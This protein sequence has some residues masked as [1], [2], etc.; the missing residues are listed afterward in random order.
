MLPASYIRRCLGT[1]SVNALEIYSP[2]AVF[3]VKHFGIFSLYLIMSRVY[4]FPKGPAIEPRQSNTLRS[5]DREVQKSVEHVTHALLTAASP[6]D[7]VYI[8]K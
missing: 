2:S 5:R 3:I 6:S 1:T 8:R 7:Y 4:D